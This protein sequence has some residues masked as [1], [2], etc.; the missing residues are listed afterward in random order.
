[1]RHRCRKGIARERRVDRY[2]DPSTDQFLSVDPLVAETGQPY[3]FVGDDPLN[4]SDPLGQ[5]PTPCGAN[6]APGEQQA[7]TNGFAAAQQTAIQA[8]ISSSA[9]SSKPATPT[10]FAVALL[11]AV[12]APASKANIQFILSWA[13]L[14]G[15]NDWNG[16][17]NP[18][19]KF[20]PL[21]AGWMDGSVSCNS[22]GVQS[23]PSWMD[24]ITAVSHEI[25]RD[26]PLIGEA[27]QQD[28]QAQAGYEVQN[29]PSLAPSASPQT[30]GTDADPYTTSTYGS[31]WNYNTNTPWNTPISG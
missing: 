12:S 10:N 24:G 6:C 18:V 16:N 4:R 17:Q 20:N 13:E 14:E 21:D 19:C 11:N 15:G 27:L 28:D 1:V 2:Y 5:I 31:V 7:I 25:E 30:W 8:P 9:P 23:Y 22:S 26:Y 29:E 3:A